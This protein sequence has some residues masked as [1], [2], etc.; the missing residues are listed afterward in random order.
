[1]ATDLDKLLSFLLVEEIGP[2]LFR[3]SSPPRP[4]RVFGG[5]VAAQALDAATRTVEEDRLAHSMHAYF[6]R[7]G[8]PAKDIHFEVER[9]RDGR[10][11]TT[12]DVVA[13]QGG[14]A[15]FTTSISFHIHEA[16]LEHSDDMPEVPAP[17]GLETDHARWTRLAEQYPDRFDPPLL[18]PIERRPVNPR[19][20]LSD[21]IREPQ[22]QIWFRAMGDPGDDPRRHQILLT[23]M[24]DFGLLGTTL[25]PHPHHGFDKD[26]QSASLDHA[27]WFH[28]PFRADEY[29]LYCLD[30]P[31]G[32]GGRG[33]ARGSFFSQ[34]GRLVA[35][36]AQECLIRVRRD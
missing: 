11:F 18:Q 33:F 28:Q 31:V 13:K 9:R 6:L 27:L 16:G 20:S 12:R 35:S 23:F 1:M 30:S 3:G 17:D 8:D 22:Q 26:M 36:S 34:D 29:L 7:P 15:I 19:D 5:Q 4:R 25:M 32:A 10:S 21:D 24:S 2:D 14:V